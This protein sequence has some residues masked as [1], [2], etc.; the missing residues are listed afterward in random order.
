MSKPDLSS[1][2]KVRFQHLHNARYAKLR[3]QVKFWDWYGFHGYFEL[4]VLKPGGLTF[5]IEE[6]ASII[7]LSPVLINEV[8]IPFWLKSYCRTEVGTHQVGFC[9]DKRL[10]YKHHS[11]G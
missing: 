6:D 9:S 7:N 3:R 11:P 1:N 5:V 8:R 2:R 10:G 4:K